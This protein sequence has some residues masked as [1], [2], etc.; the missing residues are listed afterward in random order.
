MNCEIIYQKLLDIEG[1]LSVMETK[2]DGLKKTSDET[3]VRM[4]PR[5]VA[6]IIGLVVSA[7]TGTQLVI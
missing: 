7:M 2:V 6:I 1:R 5:T 3:I 4:T